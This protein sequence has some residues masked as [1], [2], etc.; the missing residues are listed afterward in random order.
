MPNNTVIKSLHC[1]LTAVLLLLVGGYAAYQY[2]FNGPPDDVFFSRQK[3]TDTTFLYITRYKGGG[4][5]VSEVYRYYL[6]G[7]LSGDPMEHLKSRAPFLISAVSNAKVTG[8]GS[9]V[10]VTLTGRVY[11]FTNSDLFYSDG[12][13][14]M[15]VI[16]F[17]A[18]GS[19]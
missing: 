8:Y 6:D 19:R 16:S 14:I 3:V 15:P 10:N 18:N 11:S 4:A 13:A 17:T 12:V 1:T 9:H 2:Y 7:N 5:T